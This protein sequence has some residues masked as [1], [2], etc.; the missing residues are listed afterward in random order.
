MMVMKRVSLFLSAVLAILSCTPQDSK[1]K[2]FY[3]AAYSVDYP[4]KASN[5]VGEPGYLCAYLSWDAPVSPTCTHAKVY[6][7]FK[8]DSLEVDYAVPGVISDARV[9][10]KVENLEEAD[11]TFDVYVFDRVGNRSLVSEV[12]VSPRG[13]SILEGEIGRPVMGAV[14]SEI[15]ACVVINWGDAAENVLLSEIKYL[16]ANGELKV[17]QV[18]LTE[19]ST[20]LEDI[21]MSSENIEYRSAVT[22]PDFDGPIYLDWRSADLFLDPDYAE[23][24]GPGTEFITCRDRKNETITI[25]SDHPG[26]FEILCQTAAPE[27]YTN[28]LENPK[29]GTVL[30]F[31]YKQ[32]YASTTAKM[33]FF[34]KGGKLNTSRAIDLDFSSFTYGVDKWS[35]A[36]I[37]MTDAFSKHSWA[38]N[39]GDFVR[40]DLKTKA[41]N[42]ITIRNAHLRPQRN[43]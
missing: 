18:P 38:G 20:T 2:E 9:S 42:V 34:D 4:Q 14:I 41:N 37:D 33:Y 19:R 30:V 35:V 8:R 6:W 22:I 5:L 43:D 15:D 27:F 23:N 40:I 31:Q 11:Y 16:A 29:Q 7:N 17:L 12:L 32:L 3:D 36:V 28:A 13:P 39:E 24:P 21:D 1:Y 25:D 10:V 26:L